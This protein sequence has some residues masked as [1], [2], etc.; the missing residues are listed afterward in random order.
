MTDSNQ[1][2][3]APLKEADWELDFY[4][5]PIIESDGKKRWEVL[6]SSTPDL[7]RKDLFRWEKC[8]PAKSILTAPF[9]CNTSLLNEPQ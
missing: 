5:R 4:S 1:L 9:T 3:T 2:N 6:I 7:Y 8:C